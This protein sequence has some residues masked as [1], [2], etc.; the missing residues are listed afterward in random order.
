MK[1][2]EIYKEIRRLRQRQDQLIDILESLLFALDYFNYHSESYHNNKTF[3]YLI[4][5]LY[6][7]IQPF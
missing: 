7:D 2:T 5:K 6:D 4:K 1:T 3:T